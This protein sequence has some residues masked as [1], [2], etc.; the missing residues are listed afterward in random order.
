MYTVYTHTKSA[1]GNPAAQWTRIL[2][3]ES[4]TE[5]LA[6]WKAATTRYAS[7]LL[8]GTLIHTGKP[9]SY[10]DPYE[11]TYGT[12]AYFQELDR[13]D[14]ERPAHPRVGSRRITLEPTS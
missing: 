4:H 9:D 1:Y 14:R 6:A 7:I 13:C 8:D 3:T 10:R 11:P 12:T 2:A 5:A